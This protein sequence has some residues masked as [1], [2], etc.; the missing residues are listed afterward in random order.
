M[1][2]IERANMLIK[3]ELSRTILQELDI[4]SSTLVTIT[5]VECATNM[6]Y[7]KVFISII[8]ETE[9]R[10]ILGFL[11]RNVSEIQHK[12]NKRLKIRPVP[13]I[14]FVKEEKTE[15]AAKIEELLHRA[16]KK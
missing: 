3:K 8:P 7:A 2:K 9:Q 15:E 16:R 1:F 6:F 4:A 13:R 10:G 11:E 14:E 12:L 5:R